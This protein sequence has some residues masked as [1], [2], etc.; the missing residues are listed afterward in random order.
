[1]SYPGGIWS[2]MIRLTCSVNFEPLPLELV[3]RFEA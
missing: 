3:L 1:M 2:A